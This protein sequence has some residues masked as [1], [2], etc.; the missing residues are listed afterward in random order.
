MLV[1]LPKIDRILAA[2]GEIRPVFEKA[3]E[4]RELSRLCSEFLPPE[5]GPFVQAAN[6]KDGKLILL[7]ANPA[8][9]SK[10]RLLAE[11]LGVF[12]SKERP[13]VSGVSIR[14]QPNA[15]RPADGAARKNVRFS[16]SSLAELQALYARLLDSPARTAL[17]ALLEHHA[18]GGPAKAPPV[19]AR[20]EASAVPP[21][22]KKA[23]T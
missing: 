13:E 15:S 20:K 17:G 16:A 3:R 8:T 2:D 22:S 18:S 5:L 9:A 23:R 7:A 21:G 1:Q 11:S 12:L 14:V 19:G 4:I 6:I 10:L